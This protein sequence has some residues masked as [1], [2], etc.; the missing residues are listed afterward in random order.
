VISARNKGVARRALLKSAGVNTASLR[1]IDAV[2]A[3]LCALAAA[4]L[5]RNEY[6]TY[7][8]RLEGFI[9]VPP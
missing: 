4:Y 2:D 5:L 3:A 1:S 9:V 7:G 6:K 8:D